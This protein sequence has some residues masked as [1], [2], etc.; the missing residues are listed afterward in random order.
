MSA[1]SLQYI[2]TLFFRKSYMLHSVLYIYSY[3]AYIGT[4]IGFTFRHWVWLNTCHDCKTFSISTS[5][6]LGSLLKR[7]PSVILVLTCPLGM[8]QETALE[9]DLLCWRQ[10]WPSLRL[11]ASSGL[12]WL[13]RQRWSSLY[14]TICICIQYYSC[15]P[16]LSFALQFQVPLEVT[17]GLTL[18]PKDGLFV[19]FELRKW[20]RNGC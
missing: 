16:C 13:Q 8:V 5:Y 9:W 1:Y 14:V 12:C 7:R 4:Y 11:S 10:R 20:W 18:K 15:L 3:F 6:I 2:N 17:Q 19:K